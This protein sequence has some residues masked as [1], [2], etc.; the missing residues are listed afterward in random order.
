MVRK[1]LFIITLSLIALIS[2]RAQKGS[3]N[4]VE[5]EFYVSGV[6]EVHLSGSGEVKIKIGDV[7]EVIVR[8][9]DNL[10]EKLDV[11]VHKGTLELGQYKGHNWNINPS[12][13]I[14]YLVTVKELEGLGVSGSGEMKVED[15]I[16][17]DDFEMNI[18]GSCR[19]G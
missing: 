9:D 18:S 4:I 2:C 10:I 3:G 11:E 6:R 8:G 16:T 7:E 13:P 17:A 14:E 12:Q 1:T 15:K 5:K 19:Q